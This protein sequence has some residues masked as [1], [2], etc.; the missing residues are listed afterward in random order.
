MNKKI[1]S[2]L[3]LSILTFTVVMT[4]CNS[5]NSKQIETTAAT[6]ASAEKEV[7]ADSE[8]ILKE[9]FAKS[10][11]G[12]NPLYGTWAIEDFDYVSFIFRNDELAELAMGTEG[13]FSAL[14]IDESKKTLDTS[15]IVGLQG[16]YSY[17]L[18]DDEKTLTLTAEKT[19]AETVLTRQEPY[20]FIPDAPEKTVIDENILGWWTGENSQIFYFGKDGI[21]Y[22]NIISSETCYTYEAKDGKINAVYDI[23][24]DVNYDVEYQYKDGTLTIDGNDYEKFDPFEAE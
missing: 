9:Y 12:D 20:D 1:L 7:S 10:V 2:F 17:E 4:G 15:F 23:G 21:M 13:S 18:S 5:D 19:N 3:L 24:G 11:E 14:E 6:E 22:S 16:K 8:A